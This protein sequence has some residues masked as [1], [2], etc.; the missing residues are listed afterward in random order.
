[1]KPSENAESRIIIGTPDLELTNQESEAIAGGR[2]TNVRANANGI[3]LLGQA[4]QTPV[5]A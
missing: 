5:S 4:G 2:I 3:G 1:M